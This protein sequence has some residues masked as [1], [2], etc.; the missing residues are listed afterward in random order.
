[1][2]R[3]TVAQGTALYVGA[4]LGTGVLA[5]PGLAAGIAGPASLLAWAAL[6]VMSVPLAA[7]FAAL[8][9]RYPDA[10]GVATFAE[11]AFGRP[12]ATVTGWWFY[13]VVPIGVPALGMFG[14]AYVASA[15]GGGR[16]V[17]LVTAG[18]LVAVAL[19]ANWGGLRVS[20][21]LQLALMGVLAA[22]LVVTIV[23]SAPH[24]RVENLTP[25]APYGL[26]AVAPAMA[27]LL[28]SFNGW[29]AMAQ[30]SGEFA[31]PA[32][33][34]RRATAAALVIVGVLYLGVAATSVLVLGPGAGRTDAPL[35]VMLARALG[36]SAQHAAAI[37]AVVITLGPLNAYL[38]SAAR[39][40]AALGRD[41]A[42]P[43]WLARGGRAG[44]V[45]RRSLAVLAAGTVLVFAGAAGFGW[46][47][48]RLVLIATAFLVATYAMGMAA[49][50]RLLPRYRAGWW[51]ALAGLLF[52]LGLL[53]IGGWHVLG[54]LAVAAAALV[55]E[56]LRRTE[57]A[58]AREPYRVG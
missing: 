42:L 52:E 38:A 46:S 50:L 1:M 28:W 37:V 24:A 49:A 5:L 22:L 16:A 53:A 39:L 58:A 20:G 9:G 48:D 10:G 44:E 27:L 47:A 8:G 4:V 14:G 21:R 31:D 55:S 43:S 34:I 51:A 11:R 54:P 17:T 29:E 6:V 18:V 30:L 19:G 56:R 45:P 35:A 15:V 36:S 41:R 26:S 13:L 57:G 40:G 12:A 23:V 33:D 32:R 7:V 25:F 3:L 2:S